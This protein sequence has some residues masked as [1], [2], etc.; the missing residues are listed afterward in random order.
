MSQSYCY[1]LFLH[2]IKGPWRIGHLPKVFQ[3]PWARSLQSCDLTPGPTHSPLQITQYREIEH[4]K[5]RDVSGAQTCLEAVCIMTESS[6]YQVKPALSP[7]PDSG[8]P[9]CL[10]LGRRSTKYFETLVSS[11][12]Q[13]GNISHSPLEHL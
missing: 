13:W 4:K 6:G 10:V 1:P 11:P 2:S 12:V 8:F 3:R 5:H 7:N 9:G